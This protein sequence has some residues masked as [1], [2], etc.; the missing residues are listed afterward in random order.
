MY[1]IHLVLI[2]YNRRNAFQAKKFQES[3]NSLSFHNFPAWFIFFILGVDFN[4]IASIIVY[5][6]R[7][8][9]STKI[10][11]HLWKMNP[12]FNKIKSNVYLF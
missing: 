12:K 10:D 1:C 7:H 8:P 5:G 4:P 3:Q 2:V 11:Q 6:D 9:R